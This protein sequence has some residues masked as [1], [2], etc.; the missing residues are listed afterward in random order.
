MGRKRRWGRGQSLAQGDWLHGG[1]KEG[2]QNCLSTATATATATALP[3]GMA[4]I[5]FGAM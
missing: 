2:G 4:P 3:R 1:R 5:L